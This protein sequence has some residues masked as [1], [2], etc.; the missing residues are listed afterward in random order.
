VHQLAVAHHGD[1]PAG[2]E[3]VV[4]VA[5]EVPVDPGETVGVEPDGGGEVDRDP[6]MGSWPM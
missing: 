6:D 5:L 4:D 3:P 2:Q 1:Q